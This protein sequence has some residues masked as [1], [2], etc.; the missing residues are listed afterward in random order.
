M[1]GCNWRLARSNCTSSISCTR[2]TAKMIVFGMDPRMSAACAE[3][4]SVHAE[5]VIVG[6]GINVACSE[7]GI[8]VQSSGMVA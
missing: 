8:G 4:T 1:V 2:E 5:R 6:E 7:E 3:Q